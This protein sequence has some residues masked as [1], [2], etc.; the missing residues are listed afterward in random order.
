MEQS[1]LV[2]Q[3]ITHIKYNNYTFKTIIRNFS[4]NLN[5][6]R[7]NILSQVNIDVN[8]WLNNQYDLNVLKS[9]QKI[10]INDLL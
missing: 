5:I 3:L 8:Q 10:I 1:K 6:Y 2:S 9:L 7:D 4:K